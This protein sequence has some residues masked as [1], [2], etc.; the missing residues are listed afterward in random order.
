MSL[1][2]VDL[3]L[4]PL[5]GLRVGLLL[6]RDSVERI[7]PDDL[8]AERRGE[9]GA[10]DERPQLDELVS[11]NR[12]GAERCPPPGEPDVPAHPARRACPSREDAAG[13]A[14]DR[15]ESVE[16]RVPLIPPDLEVDVD[17]VVACD[18]DTA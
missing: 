15:D 4:V 17:D 13:R 9:G 7:P 6:G 18:R 14:L 16:R 5:V 1:E 8:H 2:P 10:R 12:D 3:L 11:G